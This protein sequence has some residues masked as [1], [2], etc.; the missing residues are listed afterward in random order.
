[1]A[2]PVT[3]VLDED[4]AAPVGAAESCTERFAADAE[5]LVLD[6]VDAAPVG[7]AES[8]TER[9]AP[10]PEPLV[11]DEVDAAPIG[12]AESCTERFAPDPEPLVLDEDGVAPV[13]VAESCTERFAPDVEPP[14]LDEDNVTI[15]EVDEICTVGTTFC[16]GGWASE[17]GTDE[18]IWDIPVERSMRLSRTSTARTGLFLDREEAPRGRRGRCAAGP[19]ASRL[20]TDRPTFGLQI[21]DADP[22]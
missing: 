19:E 5:T 13:E 2:C 10:D 22:L 14:V 1:V 11:L 4:D 12:A 15:C 21:P 9:F 18:P 20:S 17:D 8:C 3:L 6:E 16:G 7:A